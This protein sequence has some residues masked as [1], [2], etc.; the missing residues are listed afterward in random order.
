MTFL[1]G[2]TFEEVRQDVYALM[3][4]DPRIIYSLG[5]HL[6]TEFASYLQTISVGS[7]DDVSKVVATSN[8]KIASILAYR[9]HVYSV[10]DS[11]STR[12]YISNRYSDELTL[13]TNRLRTGTFVTSYRALPNVQSETIWGPFPRELFEVS[14]YDGLYLHGLVYSCLLYTSPSP[15]D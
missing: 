12:E 13:H 6:V 10:I 11:A 3:Y 5:A 8:S 7:M 2:S 9:R 4:L 1:T 15:R 14:S